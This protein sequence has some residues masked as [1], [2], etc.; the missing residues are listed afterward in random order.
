MDGCVFCQIISGDLT[1]SVV[2]EREG[3]VGFLDQRPVF[4]GHVLLVPRAR[5][6]VARPARGAT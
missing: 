4:K 1:A 2:L 6:D 5:R 3:V